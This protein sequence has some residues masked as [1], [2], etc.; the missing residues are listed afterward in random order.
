MLLK[1]CEKPLDLD[2][3]LKECPVLLKA[4]LVRTGHGV[5]E[6]L[7]NKNEVVIRDLNFSLEELFNQDLD[8][9]DNTGTDI[10]VLL[11]LSCLIDSLH[12]GAV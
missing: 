11:F 12:G 9:V 7:Q 4:S 1:H 10:R 5:T 6:S 3:R 8:D 2:S